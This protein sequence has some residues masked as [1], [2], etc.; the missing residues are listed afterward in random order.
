MSA[1]RELHQR[2]WKTAKTNRDRTAT[3][4]NVSLQILRLHKVLRI[5]GLEIAV[6]GGPHRRD[7][8]HQPFQPF[9]PFLP[10]H[11][12][13]LSLQSASRRCIGLCRLP[14]QELRAA[15]DHRWYPRRA[16]TTCLGQEPLPFILGQTL[17][18]LADLPPL[19]LSLGPVRV[20]LVPLG[21]PLGPTAPCGESAACGEILRPDGGTSNNSRGKFRQLPTGAPFCE[22]HNTRRLWR[23]SNIL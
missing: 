9:V 8:V 6:L 16:L 10:V 19:S 22:V 5:A 13:P 12:F 7:R 1:M 11:R 21:R 23:R 3:T 14:C 4:V 20:G 2:P 15:L 18:V 17:E